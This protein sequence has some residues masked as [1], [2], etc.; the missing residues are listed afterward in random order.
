VALGDT[1]A[2]ADP[3]VARVDDLFEV[4]I[5]QHFLGKRAAGTDDAGVFQNRI[6]NETEDSPRR[7]E[8]PGAG[9]TVCHKCKTARCRAAC[10]VIVPRG[11]DQSSTSTAPRVSMTF[12]PR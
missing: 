4:G 10:V 9:K 5:G 7:H 6:P 11:K 12:L 1:G 2:R 3:L 8:R